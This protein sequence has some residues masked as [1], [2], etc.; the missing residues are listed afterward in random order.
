MF[1]R[2]TALT[3]ALVLGTAVSAAFAAAQDP[4]VLARKEAMGLIGADV[5]KLTAMV[6]GETAFDA[7]QAQAWF[8]E[9]AAKAGEVP[10][11][12]EPKSNTDPESKA[13]DAIWDNWDDFVTKASGLKMA[14]NAGAGIDS[15]EALGAAMGG[16][17]E[18]CKACHSV[19]KE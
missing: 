6:K 16:L 7:A 17:G 9:I 3:A 15:P 13:K 8:S 1:T 2:N 4:D 18:A 11:L 14:A 19:Y 12:F 10:T 5:K